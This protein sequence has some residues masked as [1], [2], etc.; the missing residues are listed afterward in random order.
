MAG[1]RIGLKT[2]N[3]GGLNF[4]T[5]RPAKKNIDKQRLVDNHENTIERLVGFSVENCL[6]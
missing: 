5:T 6:A 4:F 2:D 1:A 3:E